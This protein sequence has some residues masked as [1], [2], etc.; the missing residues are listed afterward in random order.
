MVDFEK[1][2][3][4]EIEINRIKI[5]LK[6]SKSI[7]IE[8]VFQVWFFDFGITSRISKNYDL[9]YFDTKFNRCYFDK[10]QIVSFL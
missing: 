7:F 3:V 10:Y 1:F 4:I 6:I 9:I 8:S 5:F 2:A